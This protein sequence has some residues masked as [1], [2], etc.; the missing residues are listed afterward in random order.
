MSAKDRTYIDVGHHKGMAFVTG[1]YVHVSNADE[2]AKPIIGQVFKVF[3]P[4]KGAY[5]G[6]TSVSVCWYFRPEGTIHPASRLF[7]DHEILKTGYFGDHVLADVLEKVGAQFYSKAI[8]GR[9]KPPHWYPGWP[10][11]QSSLGSSLSLLAPAST[12]SLIPVSTTRQT[13]SSRATTQRS[14]R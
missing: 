6:Q 3:K 2:P 14:A 13:S 8:R 7:W 9:P 11:C 10:L 1:D 5:V 12:D 4:T